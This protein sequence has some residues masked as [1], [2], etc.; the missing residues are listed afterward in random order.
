MRTLEDPAL[1]SRQIQNMFSAIAPRYD[2]LNRLLSCGRDRHW[3]RAAVDLLAPASGE[4]YLDVATG[5]AD[6]ALEIVSRALPGIHVNG[7]DISHPMLVLGGRK[8][9]GNDLATAISLQAGCVES[10]PFPDDGFNGV[11]SA[12]GVRNFSDLIRGLEEMRRVLKPGGRIVILEFSLPENP[13]LGFIYKLYFG[14]LLPWI[15]RFVSGHRSAYRY[16]PESVSEFP[17]GSDFVRHLERA[18]FGQTTCQSLTFGIVNI[19]SGNKN[20]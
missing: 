12:F 1:F 2:F 5:T 19:Y 18:G 14:R 20:A 15:G 17:S 3:R 9:R 13:F 11:I 7:V 6:V 16:L 8:V 10:L 4:R